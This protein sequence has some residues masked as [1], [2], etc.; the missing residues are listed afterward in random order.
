MRQSV[1]SIYSL[2]QVIL[3]RKVVA[4]VMVCNV[5]FSNIFSSGQFYLVEENGVLRENHQLQ[6]TDKLDHILVVD[7]AKILPCNKTLSFA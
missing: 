6:V 2:I 7:Q 4:M 5:I 3:E 1:V